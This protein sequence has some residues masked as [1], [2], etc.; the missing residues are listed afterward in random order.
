MGLCIMWV[1]RRWFSRGWGPV[2]TL[3]TKT[4]KIYL[5]IRCRL[6]PYVIYENELR[7]PYDF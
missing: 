6:R 7:G 1:N 3:K 5:R 2:V 4:R